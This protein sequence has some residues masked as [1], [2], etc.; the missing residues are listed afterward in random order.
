M[1]EVSAT[2]AEKIDQN[3]A[4]EIELWLFLFNERLSHI[5]R[6]KICVTALTLDWMLGFFKSVGLVT[7][8]FKSVGLV[9]R[10]FKS[11][12]LVTKYMYFKYV[13][14]LLGN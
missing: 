14:W 3:P 10:Y 1:C 2:Y 7:G 11:V 6:V 8:Y 12:G 4:I 13:D 9:V 5:V